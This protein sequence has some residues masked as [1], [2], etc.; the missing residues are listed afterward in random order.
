MSRIIP[1]FHIAERVAKMKYRSLGK[2]GMNVSILSM[3]GSAFSNIYGEYNFEETT[4]VVHNALKWGINYVDTAPWYG[5]GESEKF[6]G[7]ALKGVPREAYYIATKVGRYDPEIRK[8]FNFRP[9]RIKASILE[10]LE[11]LGLNYVD[12]LQVHDVEFAPD[13]VTSPDTDYVCDVVLPA[14]KEIK[15]S[16][17]CRFIGITGYPPSV[18]KEIVNKSSVEIDSVLSYSRLTL[19]DSSLKDYFDFFQSKG[20]PIINAS[21]VAMGLL[22]DS[23]P[24]PWHPAPENIK[25]VCSKAVKYCKEQGVDIAK[26]AF[27]FSLSFTQVSG[28]L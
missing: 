19:N 13:I 16:G 14:M 7:E 12:I 10:S 18:L 28:Q 24:Q 4:A 25:Q 8:M 22:T 9:E 5:Q 27:D 11:R 21:P 2:T 6:L 1:G 26:L 15:D 23:G 20:V 3:G 17:L